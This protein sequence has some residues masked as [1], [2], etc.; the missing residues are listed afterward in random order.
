MCHSDTHKHKLD[1]SLNS[2]EINPN[3]SLSSYCISRTNPASPLPLGHTLTGTYDK[4][5]KHSLDSPIKLFSYRLSIW[6][7]LLTDIFSLILTLTQTCVGP[8]ESH[9]NDTEHDCNSHLHNL[10]LH[11][12]AITAVAE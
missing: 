2:N 1:Y 9:L 10:C 12:T 3:S 6:R 11:I 4:T 8:A 7:L 5:S